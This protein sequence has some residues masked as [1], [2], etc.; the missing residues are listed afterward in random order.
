MASKLGIINAALG[1]LGEPPLTN[2][3]EGNKLVKVSEIYYDMSR[4]CALK[5]HP[6]NF[7]IKRAELTQDATAPVFEFAYRYQLPTECLK[8]LYTDDDILNRDSGDRW[9]YKVE[10]RFLITDLSTVKIKY[11]AR[12]TEEGSYDPEFVIAFATY[13]AYMM[14]MSLTEHRN[15]ANDLFVLFKQ[16]VSDARFSESQEGT[17]D[18]P[19]EGGWLASRG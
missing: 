5:A 17:P 14:A 4:D 11:I 16:K 12:I 15:Q 9:P 13:L 3:T 1:F 8:V 2:L 7:A 19:I 18:P 10:G 6:W